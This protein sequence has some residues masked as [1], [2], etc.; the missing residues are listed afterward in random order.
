MSATR[1]AGVASPCINVCRIDPSGR[2]CVGCLRTLEEIARWV[3]YTDD[4]KRAV[5]A[6]LPYRRA[7]AGPGEGASP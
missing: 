4:E 7:L 2:H 1:D 6:A 3:T 5:V